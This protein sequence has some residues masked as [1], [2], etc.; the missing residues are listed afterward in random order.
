[1]HLAA[2]R[3]NGAAAHEQHFMSCVAQ[4]TEHPGKLIQ[5]AQ[6]Q[7]PLACVIVELPTL[8]TIL[9]FP[10][11][12]PVSHYIPSGLQ[13]QTKKALRHRQ[14]LSHLLVFPRS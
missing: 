4:V 11:P 10:C 13:T 14:D 1:M 3:G 8:I 7:Q 6:I 12:S 5:L 2:S 9:L